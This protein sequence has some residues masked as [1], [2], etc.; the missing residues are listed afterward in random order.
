M[1][2]KRLFSVALIV[3][4]TGG[5]RVADCDSGTEGYYRKGERPMAATPNIEVQEVD[6]VN[7]VVGQYLVSQ[8]NWRPDQFRLEHRG[9]SADGH[10]I[11]VWAIFLEDQIHPVPGGGKSVELHLDR[12]TQR[13]VRELGFQ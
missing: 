8:K 9:F 13:V 3:S 4:I 2:N 12:N 11:I 10:A 5:V 6:Q 7:I 1:V